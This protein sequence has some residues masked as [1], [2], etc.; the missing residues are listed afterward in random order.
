MFWLYCNCSKQGLTGYSLPTTMG[1]RLTFIKYRTTKDLKQKH[2]GLT[3]G[4]LSSYR[5]CPRSPCVCATLFASALQASHRWSLS[6]Y[7]ATG[8]RS[9]RSLSPSAPPPDLLSLDRRRVC[10]TLRLSRAR[11]PTAPPSYSY[12]T[13]SSN[14]NQR[15]LLRKNN[16]APAMTKQSPLC[17]SQDFSGLTAQ[18]LRDRKSTRLNSSH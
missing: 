13:L 3:A 17:S 8:E 12:A 6:R 9:L 14:R 11:A 18:Q 1:A 15:F 5:V 2:H 4:T 16:W 10:A 7:H